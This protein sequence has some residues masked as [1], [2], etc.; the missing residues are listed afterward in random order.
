[1]LS[2]NELL[3]DGLCLVFLAQ[4]HEQQLYAAR[5]TELIEDSEQAVFDRMLAEM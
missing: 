2:I 5:Y 3:K 4:C 1:M